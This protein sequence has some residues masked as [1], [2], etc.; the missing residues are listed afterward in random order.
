[1]CFGKDPQIYT[2]TQTDI[3]LLPTKNR[4]KPTTRDTQLKASCN[5]V[6]MDVRLFWVNVSDSF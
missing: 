4:K 1:M 3:F 6:G 5:N 2:H